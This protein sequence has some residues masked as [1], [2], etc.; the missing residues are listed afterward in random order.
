M[1][2]PN[3]RP[4]TTSGYFSSNPA[5]ANQLFHASGLSGVSAF[6]LLRLRAVASPVFGASATGAFVPMVVLGDALA[7]ESPLPVDA[8]LDPF[9]VLETSFVVATAARWSAVP[10]LGGATVA[11]V[12]VV[13][14]KADGA[15]AGGGALLCRLV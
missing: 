7:N 12:V 6:C 2:K 15:Y 9:G 14:A 3:S 5:A 4:A 10:G 11:H 8:K 1:S 13:T